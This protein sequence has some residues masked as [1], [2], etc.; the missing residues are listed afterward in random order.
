[1]ANIKKVVQNHLP[2]GKVDEIAFEG[3]N[4]ILYSKDRDF[5]FDNDDLI[6]DVVNKIKK[7]IELRPDPEL[8]MDEADAREKIES[9]VPDEANVDKITFDSERSIVI[10]E[11]E[12]TH[13]L[14]GRDSDIQET[15]KRETYWIP[16]IKRTPIIRSPIIENIRSVLYEH[17]KERRDFLNETGER[18]YNGWQKNKKQDEWVRLSFLGGSRQVG[19]S[20]LL[21]QTPE[22]KIMLDCGIDVAGE[23]EGAYP[24]L[25]APEFNIRDIDAVIVTHCHVDHTGLVPYLYKFGYDGPV[26]CT[27]PTRDI[28][29][30]LQLDTI[31]IHQNEGKKELY[32]QEHVKQM[33]EHTIPLDYRQVTDLTP[34]VRLTLYNA[35]HTIGSAMAHLNIGNGLH[36]LLYTGDIKYKDTR[37]LSKAHTRFRRVETMVLE[38]TYGGKDCKSNDEDQDEKLSAIVK[39]TIN[40]DGKVLMPVLGSGRGQEI[41]MMIV[42]LMQNNEIPAVPIYVD[43]MVWDITAIHTAYPEFLNRNV[44]HEIFNKDNNPFTHDSITRV[45]SHRERQQIIEEEEPCIILATS[46]MLVGGPSVEYLKGLAEDE[47]SSLI[48]SCYQGDGSLGRKIQRGQRRITFREGSQEEHLQLKMNISKIEVSGHADRDELMHFVNRLKPQPNRIL[49]NHGDKDR[50]IDLRTSLHKRFHMRTEVPHNLDC[51]RLE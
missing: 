4:I 24:Y 44:R 20:C 43:G 23:G 13:L 25:Q 46:G 14:N 6:K 3:A 15:I 10:I 26:Y 22:S 11:A 40:R 17:G 42:N 50:S 7:R 41:I 21:L 47:R 39:D 5:C 49:V 18:V 48:F 1:V 8:T 33:V 36:N 34:D 30:L 37:L 9:I 19:R 32:S 38:S 2:D 29:A 27:A 31:K 35:G 28:M 51:L 12:K 16:K 45:G